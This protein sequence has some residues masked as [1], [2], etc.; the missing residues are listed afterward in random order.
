MIYGIWL[1]DLL[2]RFGG[3]GD[4]GFGDLDWILVEVGNTQGV[5][6]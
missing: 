6:Y 4:S 2:E 1:S 5:R 3:N